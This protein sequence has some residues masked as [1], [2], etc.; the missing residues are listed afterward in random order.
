LFCLSKCQKIIGSYWSS[1]T[2]AAAEIHGI[3][4]I[5]VGAPE[6]DQRLGFNDLQVGQMVKVKVIPGDGVWVA[7]E[8]SVE[9]PVD[10][11]EIEGFIQSLGHPPNLLRLLHREFALPDSIAVKDLQRHPTNLKNLKVGDRVKLTGT[12]AAPAGFVP[13]K[14]KVQAATDSGLEE[15]RGAISKLDRETKTLEVVGFTVA[16]NEDT[17]IF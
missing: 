7:Q 12:Y 13:E 17:M 2:E 1:F 16:V 15:L 4:K 10:R 3:E 6:G 8:I 9:A 5:I 14:I 11:A